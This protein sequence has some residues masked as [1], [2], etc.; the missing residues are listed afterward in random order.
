MC[1]GLSSEVPHLISTL[2]CISFLLSYLNIS[3]LYLVR[4]PKGWGLALR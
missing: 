3:H 4:L 1:P 2:T